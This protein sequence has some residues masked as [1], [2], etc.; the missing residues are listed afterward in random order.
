MRKNREIK[1]QDIDR[2]MNLMCPEILVSGQKTREI[3]TH[4][5]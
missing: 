3:K 4:L 5:R 2:K 1:F